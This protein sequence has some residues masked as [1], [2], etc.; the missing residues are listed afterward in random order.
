MYGLLLGDGVGTFQYGVP[1][2]YVQQIE[3][4]WVAGVHVLVGEEILTAE[5]QSLF[6]VDAWSWKQDIMRMED[7][8]VVLGF[9]IY[10]Y[11]VAAVCKH[12]HYVTA[13]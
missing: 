4:Y 6:L 5:E 13:I 8:E 2:L 10:R 1:H 7:G 9:Q 12:R 3:L 11:I